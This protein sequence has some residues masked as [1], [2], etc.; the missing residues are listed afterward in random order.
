[1]GELSRTKKFF[2][3]SLT[4]A[5]YQV[6][7]MLSGFI[8]PKVMLLYYGS[9]IN[10]LVSSINQFI[11]YFNLVEAGLA[12][13]AVFA[14]Y[15]PLANK[16][17]E[18]ISSVVSATKRFYVQAGNI[19]VGL[20]FSL[21]IC[22][23]FIIRKGSLSFLMVGILVLLLGA[24]GVLE[25][26]TLA[27]YRVLLTADQKTYIISIA[28]SIYTVLNMFII[29]YL[30]KA[31]VNIV[32]L[33]ATSL[34]A[35]FAR[36]IILMI[37]VRVKYPKINY[38][39][40]P[41][42]KA[43]NKR[44]D[45]L[46]LQILGV[47][48]NGTPTVLATIFLSLT[49]VSIYAVYN[50]V[51]TGINGIL[52]IFNSGLAASFGDVLA[53]NEF[54]TLK[55]A[56][57]EFEL[58]YYIIITIIY[59]IALI[60]IMPFIKVYTM[61]VKDANYIQPIIGFLVVLNGY[62]YNLKTPQGMLVISAGHYKETKLQTLCQALILIIV[63][64]LLVKPLGLV[65]ILI[66]ACLSNIYRDIDLMVYVPNKIVK[67]SWINSFKRI[68]WSLVLLIVNYSIF[69]GRVDIYVNSYIS[70]FVVSSIV[71]IVISIIVVLSAFILD[72]K[73]V[74]GIMKRI[75]VL[76]KK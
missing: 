46:F 32:I 67:M 4:T 8:I 58:A 31:R 35:I 7:V 30:G 22:Y 59:S 54:N 48:Q 63:S 52:S 23:P 16:N 47:V 25:F 39:A 76:L 66:G 44:W 1:M 9:E 55:K 21:A 12:G 20:L 61:D 2:Y 26:Y 53:K 71:G 41:N 10:G 70:W 64:L 29:Y 18:D 34:L 49:S 51:V 38:K 75:L 15:K 27:K 33:Y 28:S 62:L 42:I 72:Y 5:F 73:Q 43:L 13:A 74:I 14:L 60:M 19:F 37:Y 24:K 11:S 6:I 50:M 36:T 3:N 45:A 57:N 69:N 68:I 56:Y 65:G 40:S 17:Y